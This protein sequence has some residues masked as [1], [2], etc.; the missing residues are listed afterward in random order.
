MPITA[1][2][3]TPEDAKSIDASSPHLARENVLW[4]GLAGPAGPQRLTPRGM[5]TPYG[6]NLTP[7]CWAGQMMM[8]SRT[9]WKLFLAQK[10]KI[11]RV[12]SE[13]DT[14]FQSQAIVVKGE[15]Q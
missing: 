1:A 9:V 2:R 10:I 15:A 14:H 6:F 7:P 8:G 5:R 3:V 12:G 4:C 11:L 13:T